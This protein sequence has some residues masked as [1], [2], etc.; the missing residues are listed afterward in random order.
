V[1]SAAVKVAEAERTTAQQG[2]HEMQLEMREMEARRKSDR[3]LQAPENASVL[4]KILSM[5]DKGGGGQHP[6]PISQSAAYYLNP[7]NTSS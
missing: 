1:L 6:P 7:Q 4:N 5:E 3:Q 2:M